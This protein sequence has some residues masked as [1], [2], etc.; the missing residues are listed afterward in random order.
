MIHPAPW[1][2]LLTSHWRVGSVGYRKRRSLS[3][4]SMGYATN[5]GTE[6]SSAERNKAVYG[7][8]CSC[9][10]ASYCRECSIP[11]GDIRQ[12]DWLAGNAAALIQA[13]PSYETS[14]T[15]QLGSVGALESGV[16]LTREFRGLWVGGTGTF[17]QP[18]GRDLSA[19]PPFPSARF[20][21][22]SR[23]SSRKRLS[24]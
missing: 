1:V 23:L 7:S 21:S 4:E 11:H 17:V 22:S 12:A 19:C 18:S 13:A 9:G 5:A 10:C 6:V 8:N 2:R 16:G 24:V 15:R 3:W 20:R 14:N